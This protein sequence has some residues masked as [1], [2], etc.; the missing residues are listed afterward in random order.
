MLQFPTSMFFQKT[1][2]G[3]GLGALLALRRSS[4]EPHVLARAGLST[5]VLSGFSRWLLAALLGLATCCLRGP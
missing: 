5:L 1:E 4:S 3:A 2:E